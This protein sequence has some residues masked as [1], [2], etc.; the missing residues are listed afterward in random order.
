ME[1]NNAFSSWVTKLICLKLRTFSHF[2]NSL[3]LQLTNIQYTPKN[4]KQMDVL[5]L[6]DTTLEECII[7]HDECDFCVNF[8]QSALFL[9]QCCRKLW[10]ERE[11]KKWLTVRWRQRC[12]CLAKERLWRDACRSPFAHCDCGREKK[13]KLWELKTCKTAV[14]LDKE[15]FDNWNYWYSAEIYMLA[16]WKRLP[17]EC[18]YQGGENDGMVCKL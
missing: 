13:Q 11:R 5:L 4:K 14:T 17:S 15:P 1:Y 3:Y 7:Q 10:R 16:C 12:S 2:H 8:R 18:C 6:C 9:T